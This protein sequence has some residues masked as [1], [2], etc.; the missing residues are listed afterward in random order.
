MKDVIGEILLRLFL[1]TQTNENKMTLAKLK[2]L[3]IYRPVFTFTAD[4]LKKYHETKK[5]L[6]QRH[7][8]H[9]K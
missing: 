4:I 1:V 6:P 2:K 5:I 3:Q 7:Q 8:L 9:R